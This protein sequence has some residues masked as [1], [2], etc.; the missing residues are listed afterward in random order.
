MQERLAPLDGMRGVAVLA[1]ICFHTGVPFAPGGER[2]V[3]MFFVLSGFLITSILLKDG[4][5]GVLAYRR[6][7]ARRFWRLTP[8][9]AAL[10]VAYVVAA[11]AIFPEAAA[12]RWREAL[13]AGAY[14][15]D[16]VAAGRATSSPLTHTWS[17]A[18]EAQF[19]LV[20]PFVVLALARLKSPAFALL[21]AWGVLTLGRIA[22]LAVTMDGRQAYFPLHAHATGLVIGAALAY[23]PQ[24]KV[25]AVAWLGVAAFTATVLLNNKDDGGISRAVWGIAGAELATV[26]ILAGLSS[27][28]AITRALSWRPLTALGVIS[29]GVYLWHWPV[30]VLLEDAPWWLALPTATA[31]AVVLA[32]ISYW[33][34]EKPARTWRRAGWRRSE[35]KPALP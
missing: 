27:S 24:V 1:V 4:T 20:W 30:A 17:L 19:Y 26:A 7:W 11:P 3:D 21:V 8:A 35:P 31:A 15:M 13:I 28:P 2:G 34:V 32:T 16:Y 29:Y 10:L 33:T 22:V 5:D 18:I 14:L 25:R 12:D 23:A 9:L 6:F